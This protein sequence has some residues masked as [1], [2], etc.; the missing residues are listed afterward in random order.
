MAIDDD[1]LQKTVRTRLRTLSVVDPTVDSLSATT[2]G[3]A[4]ASG[5]FITDGLWPGMEITPSGFAANPVAVIK[6]V[7]ATT[8]TVDETRAAEVAAGSRKLT[9]VLP[10]TQQW[11]NLGLEPVTGKPYVEEDYLGGPQTQF[12]TGTEGR[13]IYDPTYVLRLNVEEGVGAE[14]PNGYLKAL[15]ALFRP[16][17]AMLMTNGDS[18]RVRTDP[19]PFRGQLLRIRPGWATVTFTI[20]LRVYTAYA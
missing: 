9:V 4:R 3:Y 7:T 19:A 1:D 20:P 15:A 8:V 5:S 11:D 2:S 12:E 13:V 6:E 17:T 14:A 10:A 18:L 16:M